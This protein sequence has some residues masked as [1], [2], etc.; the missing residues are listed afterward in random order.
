MLQNDPLNC[1]K[2]P[3]KGLFVSVWYQTWYMLDT[4]LSGENSKCTTIYKYLN[5]GV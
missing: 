4:C 2:L 5:S 3:L 1:C